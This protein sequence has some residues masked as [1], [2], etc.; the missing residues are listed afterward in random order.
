[1][2]AI[3]S[4]IVVVDTQ[5]KQDEAE[6]LRTAEAARA[7]LLAR[8]SKGEVTL[9]EMR[10]AL[11]GKGRPDVKSLLGVPTDTG[12]DT[13]SYRQ[14]MIINPVTNLR[15]GLTVNFIEGVVQGVDYF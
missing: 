14:R 5:K 8:A 6:A 11:I 7:D 13:W 15:Y 4:Q 1:M 2:D 9:S 3:N 10:H 12:T